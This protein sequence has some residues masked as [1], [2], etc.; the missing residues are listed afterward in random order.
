MVT[1]VKAPELSGGVGWLNTSHPITLKELHGKFVLLDFW[2]FCCINCMHIIPDLKKLE[3]KFPDD[4]V[5]IGVHSAKFDNEKDSGNIREAILRY[6]IEHPVVN[7]ANFKIWNAFAVHSWPTLVL[8]DPDGN[9][10]AQFAGEGNYDRI[11]NAIETLKPKFAGK[12]NEKPLHF[13][14][15][16][17]K[18][19]PTPLA[20]PGKIIWDG[21]K[22]PSGLP[23]VP[24]TTP[25]AL[26]PRLFISD[27]GH[28]RIVVTTGDGKLIETI[29]A[30][31]EGLQDGSFQTAEFRHPQGMCFSDNKLYVADTE[32]H[33]LRLVDL[34]KKTVTTIAGDGQQ[35]AFRA[36][37]GVG[38][39]ARL[40]SPWDLVLVDGKLYIAMAG[41]HQ[42]W[43]MDLK[44]Q[45]VGP[46]AGNGR[47]DIIDGPLD[48]ASLAQPSGI[49]TDGKKLY[50]VDSEVSAVRSADLSTDGDVST[51][52]GEGLFD[53]GDVDGVGPAARLQHPLGIVWHDGKLYVA[54][55]YNHKIKEVD[56]QSKRASTLLG[57]GKA[58]TAD[59]SLNEPGGLTFMGNELLIAD[60]NNNRIRETT[61]P[62]STTKAFTIPFLAPPNAPPLTKAETQAVAKSDELP[63]MPNPEKIAITTQTVLPGSSKLDLQVNLPHGWHLND[64]TAVNYYFKQVSGKSIEFGSGSDKTSISVT[65][66]IIKPPHMPVSVPVTLTEGQSALRLIVTLYYCKGDEACSVRTLDVTAPITVS[67]KAKQSAINIHCNLP[68]PK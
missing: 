19:Q 32:N 51:I 25:S 63:A 67:S 6:G 1:G 8:I 18:L 58:G 26:G 33:A 30:G 66:G 40:S 22:A 43:M 61:L 41:C 3:T 9:I 38:K 13:D 5:V 17:Y 7:D 39:T 11:V 23:S 4:L 21:V 57:T 62:S 46:Y 15:E 34:T 68:A 35:A 64:Q 59:N 36:R 10:A 12:L 16:R 24:P 28:N 65:Q 44:S 29:G 55:S 47:E 56:P 20:F 48:Q 53:F 60:T 2:T 45:K 37:G 52:I 49:T 50:F 31:Q 27:S 42:I 54:D 14:L